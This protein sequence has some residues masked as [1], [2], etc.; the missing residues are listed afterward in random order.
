MKKFIFLFVCL[1]FAFGVKAQITREQADAIVTDQIFFSNLDDVDIYAFPNVLTDN[2]AIGLADGTSVNVPYHTCYAYFIDLMPFANWS[3]PCKYCFVNT[4]GNQTMVDAQM[5]PST[6]NLLAI[7]LVERPNFTL[8]LTIPENAHR[9]SFESGNM[10]HKWAFLICGNHHGGANPKRFWFDLSSVYT[11]L[12]NVYHYQEPA[13]ENEYDYGKRRVFVTAPDGVGDGISTLYIPNNDDYSLYYSSELN[14]NLHAG[15]FMYNGDFINNDPHDYDD[16]ANHSKENIHNIFEC[17]A[18]GAHSE[19]YRRLGYELRELT[20]EDELFIYITGHGSNEGGNCCFSIQNSAKDVTYEKI[21]DEELTEWLRGIKCS[22]ITLVMQNCNSG[23]FI[24]K[25]LDDIN[26]ENCRCKNRIGLSAASADGISRAESY[27]ITN[28]SRKMD[29]PGFVNEFTYYWTAAALGYYPIYKLND[30]GNLVDIGP[31][32]PSGR[33]IADGTMNWRDYFHEK[34]DIKPHADYEEDPDTDHD[35]ILSFKELF[36][37]ANNLDSWSWDGYYYPNI[38]DTT[39][40]YDPYTPEFPQ[41]AYESSFTAEAATLRGY[42]GQVD[43]D[44]TSGTAEQPYRLVGDLWT[45]PH[46]RVDMTD[47]IYVPEGNKIYIQPSSYIHLGNCTVDK[48]P[49]SNGMWE[50]IQVWGQNDQP[51]DLQH[52]GGLYMDNASIKNAIVAVDLW[53]PWVYE[54]TGG[55]FSANNSTFI[56]NA[57]GLRI[58]EYQYRDADDNI[59]DYNADLKNCTF[60]VNDNFIG[61]ENFYEHVKLVH[62]K[63]LRFD[64]CKFKL[65]LERPNSHVASWA[66]G[67]LAFDAGFRLDSYDWLGHPMNQAEVKGLFMG[68][69]AVHDLEVDPAPFNIFNTNFIDNDCGVFASQVGLPTIV[70]SN[71]LIGRQGTD[72]AMGIY[73]EGINRFTIE[74]NN[75]R[76][77]EHAPQNNYGIVIKESHSEGTQIYNNN[78]SNLYCGNL[79]IGLNRSENGEGLE[80]R[81]NDNSSN[82]IDFYVWNENNNSAGVKSFQ[83]LST[84]AAD[85]K[86]SHDAYH[87][88]NGGTNKVIYYYQRNAADEQ[89]IRYNTAV[90]VYDTET[91]DGCPLRYD[92]HVSSGKLPLLSASK[93]LERETDYY[94]ALN[95]YNSVK[96][97]YNRLTDGG[98]TNGTI[99]SI[100]TANPWQMWDL[101]A[102]LLGASP[103]LSEEV[104]K[105]VADRNDVFTESVLFEILASNPDE[106]KKGDIIDYVKNKTNPLPSYMTDILEQ[107]AAGN[108]Y[109]TVLLN[110]MSSYSRDYHNAATDIIRSIL[111]DSIV[112]TT[113]LRGWLGNLNDLGADREIIASYMAEGD[114]DNAFA[115]A[116]MLPT[117]Y[118]FGSEEMDEHA[119]Y[120]RMLNLYRSLR[121]A[122]RNTRQLT[123]QEIEDI[124]DIAENS[125]GTPQRMAQNILEANSLRHFADCPNAPY[126][127]GQRGSSDGQID[128]ELF[129][130]AMGLSVEA[131]PN[132]ATTWVAIDYTLPGDA[133]K[134][135]LT[136]TNAL[137]VKVASY[138]LSGHQ[139][140]KVL[141]LR[142]FASGVYTCTIACGEYFQTQKIVITQ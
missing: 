105:E 69:H 51:Q 73:V 114:F 20:E 77:A 87:F 95:T 1:L 4:N 80:Y 103:Y 24:D 56:N 9:N 106:L 29:G 116:N 62:V 18:T 126:P 81:C 91:S 66:K 13:P 2:E 46:T 53:N 38:G 71:F 108:T 50:G 52:Q 135:I 7:S 75:F 41:S 5:A 124:E 25:F 48:L 85:N 117:L 104:L 78:F 89:P 100:K 72:C 94:N 68:V 139:G 55:I 119:D 64:G 10:D 101:R 99:S 84:L 8:D 30:D 97:L 122:G 133:E 6:E 129:G 96:T 35:E 140:Q 123:Q 125:T 115:L 127:G 16:I 74:Q 120:M 47:D 98:N 83:G 110:Q 22:Q 136:L 141:D 109:K 92:T 82:D 45:G 121:Q 70:N 137:G 21:F 111:A 130:K 33:N 79:A 37:F 134:A 142:E 34:E 27:G 42:E 118:E 28:Y 19:E 88:F 14:E 36:E 60:L 43:G 17:F 86:F 31:W 102:Q 58:E 49:E 107:V 54:T 32:T 131:K 113:E 61:T 132:P 63:G 138:N 3:H 15:N 12:T 44:V 57:K 11:V 39:N 59:I 93:R 67:I 26:N 65:E 40:L 76:K 128:P 90:T 23:G 112:N